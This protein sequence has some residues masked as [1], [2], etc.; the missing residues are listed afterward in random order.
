[1]GVKRDL[2]KIVSKKQLVVIE[3]AVTFEPIIKVWCLLQFRNFIF[4]P[5]K[6]DLWWKTKKLSLFWRNWQFI[7][8]DDRPNWSLD[9]FSEKG[10]LVS[11]TLFN[12]KS[13]ALLVPVVA[14]GDKQQIHTRTSR[15]LD[16]IGLGADAVKT[17][18]FSSSLLWSSLSRF[19]STICG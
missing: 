18:F 3:I 2:Q 12:Q 5:D 9:Q 7:N 14:G 8:W 10:F 13:P 17:S 15:S 11:D 1:M 16:R 19:S 4:I 6:V